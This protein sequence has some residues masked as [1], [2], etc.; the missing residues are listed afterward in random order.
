MSFTGKIIVA[1]IAGICT[2]LVFFFFGPALEPVSGLLVGGLLDAI[3]RIFITLLR[4]MVVPLVLV[5][6][7]CGVTALGDF[8]TLGRVGLKTIGLYTATTA[9]ALVIALTVAS[10]ISPGEGAELGAAVGLTSAEVPSLREVL[11]GM[12][13]QNPIRALAEGDT[14]QIIVFA[15]FFGFA[16]S[17]AGEAGRRI[18]AVFHD[19]NHIVTQMV[20]FI[21]K[22]APIGVFA[23]MATVFADRGLALLQPMLGYAFTLVLALC[24]H[25]LIVYSSLLRFAGLSVRTFFLQ[26]RGVMT[27]AFSTSSSSA[28]IPVTLSTLERRMG[29]KNSIA[30]FTVPLGATVNMDGTAIMQGVATVFLANAYGVD[31]GLS[32]F[33]IVILTATLA[34]IGTAA[35]PSAGTVML[36]MVLVQVGLPAEGAGFILAVDRLLDMLRTAVNVCGDSAVTCVVA[37]SENALDEDV[38]NDLEVSIES[39][40]AREEG[41]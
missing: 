14:L 39:S 10:L 8:R 18:A 9:V 37:R 22:T 12:F 1:M 25:V 7:V 5:S 32:D 28:T 16:L 24:L 23:L 11:I 13:P 20:L 41:R 21:V 27:F 40:V 2:G 33:L 31:L 34:S 4:M 15:L 38:F 26:I 3:G 35:V 19:L 17:Q 6:L 29:V 36:I 30:S